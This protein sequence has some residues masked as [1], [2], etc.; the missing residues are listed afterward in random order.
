MNILF[1]IPAL[2]AGGAERVMVTLA[3]EFSKE[4][5]VTIT[6]FNEGQCFYDLDKSVTIHALQLMPPSSGIK[7]YINLPLVE[8]KRFKAIRDIIIRGNFDFI[9]SF[10]T[11]TNYMA[12][13]I[14]KLYKLKNIIIS[15]RNDPNGYSRFNKFL[16]ERLYRECSTIVCQ[17]EYVK[18][19]FEKKGFSNR[20]VVLPNPVNFSDIPEEHIEWN[21][22]IITVGR[23]IPQKNQKLLIDAFS[24]VAQDYTDYILKI[25]G[26]GYLKEEL[27]AYIN[28]KNLSHRVFLM[29][30]KKKV[31][32]EVA[33]GSI[34]VLSSDFEGFPNVLIE[35]MATQTPVISTNF[36]TGVAQELI[37]DGKN[38]YLVKVGDVD[39]LEKAMRKLL[40]RTNEFE[41]MG[42][43]NRRVAFQYRGSVVAEKWVTTIISALR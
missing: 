1:L 21:K 27:E 4:H 34:F 36:E 14:A 37:E 35:A 11:T 2:N 39:G 22:E 43:R 41:R 42:E 13:L 8:Y 32:Y 28:E 3:N 18:G 29:G 16:I 19:F 38:G 40:G 5:K 23:L 7:R 31:M 30:T 20:L 6:V 25:Y 10:C 9:L 17:N 33:K 24:N 15:E 12:C 26:K